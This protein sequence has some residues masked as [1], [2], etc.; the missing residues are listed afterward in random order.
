M[1]C[2]TTV[3]EK[4]KGRARND[5]YWLRCGF[6]QHKWSISWREINHKTKM[7]IWNMWRWN[8]TH[9]K[10]TYLWPILCCVNIQ[11]YKLTK[12]QK[13]RNLQNTWS[14]WTLLLPSLPTTFCLV[15]FFCIHL[16]WHNLT[17][18][19]F[20]PPCCAFFLWDKI[21]FGVWKAFHWKV[22]PVMEG[23]RPGPA[24]TF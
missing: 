3:N 5:L 7:I 1:W 2:V 8:I 18:L 11:T 13:T 12:L 17:T 10:K 15:F 21:S 9:Q 4:W 24:K 22:K 6:S 14:E 16:G 19:S 20:L 23:C